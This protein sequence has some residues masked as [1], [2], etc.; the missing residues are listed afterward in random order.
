MGCLRG[1]WHGRPAHPGSATGARPDANPRPPYLP[2]M[3]VAITTQNLAKI[4]GH[5][6]L[7]AGVAIALDQRERAALIGPTGAV[8]PAP[9]ILA[10]LR[11][12]TSTVSLR[13]GLR[14]AYIS[15]AMCS[16]KVDGLVGGGGW[17]KGVRL[18]GIH[19][20]PSASCMRTCACG[21][22]V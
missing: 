1:G 19:D 12:P 8:S 13:K 10:G 15:R 11:P 2:A 16:P 18:R 6:Q 5:H 22:W 14:T 7:F 20:D 21:G 17:L 3:A 4:Y 9:K